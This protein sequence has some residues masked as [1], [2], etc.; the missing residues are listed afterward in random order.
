MLH[1]VGHVTG[2]GVGA[3]EPFHAGDEI[4]LGRFGHEMTM[5]THETPR[6]E[7]PAGFFTGFAE[8]VEE[9]AAI[10]IVVEDGF[11]AVPAIHQVV[12]GPGKL[13]AQG[14]RHGLRT[15]ASPAI[16]NCENP[17]TAIP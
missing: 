4:G 5:I 12:G 3:E 14:S 1:K 6:M 2:A 10:L 17:F 7:L 13:N 9:A 11:T 15:A 16:C 8:G